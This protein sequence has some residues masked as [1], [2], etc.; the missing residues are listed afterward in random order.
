MIATRIFDPCLFSTEIFRGILTFIGAL[1][2]AW[3]GLYLLQWSKTRHNGGNV[4]VEVLEPYGNETNIRVLNR[5]SFPLHNVI[6][7]LTAEHKKCDVMPNPQAVIRKPDLVVHLYEDRMAW[8]LE[9]DG[10]NHPNIDIFPN[11]RQAATFVRFH[12]NGEIE[13]PSEH[14]FAGDGQP[15]NPWSR[16]FLKKGNYNF[17]LKIVSEDSTASCWRLR[18]FE[19]KL[20]PALKIKLKEYSELLAAYKRNWLTQ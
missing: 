2:G 14:R 15:P 11:E 13:L 1:F 7:Y 17:L 3:G 12:P 16:I 9:V 8:C 4:D 5:S 18:I 19:G 10:R 6:L 20:E